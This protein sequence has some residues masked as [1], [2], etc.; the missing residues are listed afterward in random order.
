MR[1]IW[2]YLIIAVYVSGCWYGL[3]LLLKILGML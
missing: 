2:C 3:W 1:N